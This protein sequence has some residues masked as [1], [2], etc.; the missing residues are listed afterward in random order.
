MTTAR[1]QKA[2]ELTNEME[3]IYEADRDYQISFYDLLPS[4]QEKYI[5]LRDERA[6]LL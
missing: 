6:K 3:K 5:Q 2:Q 1:Q 4:D